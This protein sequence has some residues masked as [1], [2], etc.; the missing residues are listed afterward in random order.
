LRDA[1]AAVIADEIDLID[2]QGIEKFLEHLCV[3]SDGNVLVRRDFG[4]AMREQVQGNATP[5][6][7]QIFQLMTPKIAVQ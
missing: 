5:D 3:C 7:G 2:L 4:V 1:A 6:V